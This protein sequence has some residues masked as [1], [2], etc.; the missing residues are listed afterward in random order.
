MTY[1]PTSL[2][3][4]FAVVQALNFY[5]NPPL[6]AARVVAKLAAKLNNHTTQFIN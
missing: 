4:L 2:E 1:L 3:P 5:D 6:V